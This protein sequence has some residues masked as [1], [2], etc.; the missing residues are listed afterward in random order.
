MYDENDKENIKSNQWLSYISY[1][2]LKDYNIY[3]VQDE[4]ELIKYIEDYNIK[5]ILIIDDATYSGTQLRDN[6][7]DLINNIEDKDKKK[8]QIELG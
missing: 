1:P 8:K 2:L 4:K 3:V 6:I 5:N 7:E